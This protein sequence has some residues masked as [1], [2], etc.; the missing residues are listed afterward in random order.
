MRGESRPGPVVLIGAG[1]LGRDAL[2]VHHALHAEDPRWEV[3]G[4]LDDGP[5]RAGTTVLGVPVLGGT[6]W[7]ERR[8]PAD[9]QALLTVGAPAA[10]RTL[11]ARVDALGVP[12]AT[13]VH[14]TVVVT[15]WVEIG[16]GSLVMA[17]STFT[18]EVR[19]G[20]HVVVNPG[21]TVAHDVRIGEFC[22]LSPGVDLAGRVVLEPEAYLGTGAV[23]IPG[24]TV[25][26]GAVI[27]AGAV[28]VRDIP[29]GVTAV[30][31]P[32]RSREA[33]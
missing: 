1:D 30:G 15:P 20:R 6:D 22:Y 7:L 10:R 8:A 17:R 23:V 26:Q 27:G 25:G 4:F 2:S 18:V 29:A 9:V 28:V 13:W 16:E 14:P 32:A 21:C 33:R 24:R 3:V 19:L 11:A 12:W 31:V 5:G